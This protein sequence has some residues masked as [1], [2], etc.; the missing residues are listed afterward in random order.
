VRIIRPREPFIYLLVRATR[1]RGGVTCCQREVCSAY[2]AAADGEKSG[3][4]DDERERRVVEGVDE[5]NDIFIV[6]RTG[7][8]ACVRS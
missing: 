1:A 6:R 3:E 7:G 4:A 5:S 8:R 2:R